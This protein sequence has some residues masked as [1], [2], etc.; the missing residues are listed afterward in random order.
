MVNKEKIKIKKSHNNAGKNN[1]MAKFFIFLLDKFKSAQKAQ[2]NKMPNKIEIKNPVIVDFAINQ[3]LQINATVPVIKPI[4]SASTH[5]L[6]FEIATSNG[7][8]AIKNKKCSFGK[9]AENIKSPDKSAS[10]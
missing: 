9:V 7:I 5:F 3:K 10:K 2:K 8:K 1:L 4:I 6:P